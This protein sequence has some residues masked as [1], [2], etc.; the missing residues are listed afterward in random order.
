MKSVSPSA[1]DGT[2]AAPSSKS[3]LQRVVAAALLAR[4][5]SVV[6]DP[7]LCD[8]ARAAVR[9]VEA[10]GATVRMDARDMT[11]VGG[12]DP[13]ASTIDAG[14]S[15][16]ALRMFSAIASLC[17]REITI[18]AGGSLRTRPVAMIAAPLEALG[19]HVRTANGLPPVTVRGP[20]TGGAAE[21]DGSVSSQFLTGLLLALP[22]A[23]H[24]STLTVR[25]LRSAPYVRMTLDTLERFGI[26]AVHDA[27]V[28]TFSIPGR[29]AYQPGRFTIDGDWSGAAN[30]LVAGA[31][32]G[33]V[34]VTRL[35]AG[36]S[37]GDRAIVDACARA[38]A[39]VRVEGAAVTVSSAPLKAF[40]FDATDCPDLFP[41][42]VA[43][44][45]RCDGTTVL[46][47]ASRLAH[48][49]SDRAGALAREFGRLGVGVR[50][51]GDRMEVTGGEIAGGTVDAHGDHRIAMAL[52]TAALAARGAVSIA[53]SECVS[54]SFPMF[55]EDLHNLGARVA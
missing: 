2:V 48:K 12:L 22:L 16:L 52:A 42:L 46:T 27:A 10:L 3:D 50:V 8:D 5:E 37:Q 23:A 1:V 29:Q 36:S 34:T 7:T 32:A 35:A 13:R 14:E 31:I 41:P 30:M 25:G 26:A 45:S 55:F 11:I 51:A 19:A 44:A 6:V 4:G 40:A 18:T 15:G 33:R 53:G 47:G 39:T 17:A 24:D 28:G 43:L 9:I 54:K 38:G 20:L 21:V 49:E